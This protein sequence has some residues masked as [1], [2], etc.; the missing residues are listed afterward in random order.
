MVMGTILRFNEIIGHTENIKVLE[1][2]LATGKIGHAYLFVGPAGVGKKTLARCFARQVLCTGSGETDC[3]CEGCLRFENSA[4]PDFKVVDPIGNAIKVEQLREIQH[5][6]YLSPVLASKK[7]Y[8]FPEAEKLTEVAAN[9]FLKLLEEAPRG[10][11]FIFIAVRLDHILPTLR[12]RCQICQLY[13]MN[14]SELESALIHRGMTPQEAGRR[15]QMSRGLPGVAIRGIDAGAAGEYPTFDQIDRSELLDLFKLADDLDKT[16]RR[17][18]LEVLGDWQSQLRARLTGERN[19][20]N[21]GAR[22][23]RLTVNRL[24]KLNQIMTMA[25]RNV[26]MRLLLE[27]FFMIVSLDKYERN[28]SDDL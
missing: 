10:V 22:Q 21:R 11:I 18:V 28:A 24:E 7:I 15:S 1:G 2:A 17:N 20:G 9:S 26:N 5:Q 19:D 12:S 27:T 14:V 25:E 4:H 8:F 3:S 13:P 6:A 16:D 23:L